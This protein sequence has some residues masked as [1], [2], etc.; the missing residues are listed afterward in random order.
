MMRGVIAD[1]NQILRYIFVIDARL[2]AKQINRITYRS[3]K[4]HYLNKKKIFS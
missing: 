3:G 4:S 2:Q 1:V